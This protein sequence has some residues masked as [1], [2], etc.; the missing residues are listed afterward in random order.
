MHNV[1]CRWLVNCLA[2]IRQGDPS[3]ES[4][5]LFVDPIDGNPNTHMN[6]TT[7]D[8]GGVL[9]IVSAIQGQN[10]QFLRLDVAGLLISASGS[11]QIT[12]SGL[13]DGSRSQPTPIPRRT[14]LSWMPSPDAWP[15][16][17]LPPSPSSAPV[18]SLSAGCAGR[19][20][21]RVFDGKRHR[22]GR[23]LTGDLPCG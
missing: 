2:Q 10:F 12:V 8:G 20:G 9:R 3:S 19:M 22:V 7:L 21:L 14:M 17:I 16:P 5:S 1:A 6:G 4:G 23:V 11:V 13:D 15:C 18:C